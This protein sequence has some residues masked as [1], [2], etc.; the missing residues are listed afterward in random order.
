MLIS[1]TGF[2][3]DSLPKLGIIPKILLIML[4]GMPMV[5]FFSFLYYLMGGATMAKSLEKFYVLIFRL[6]GMRLVT[7]VYWVSL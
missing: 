6:P 5:F 3:L 4:S 1:H 7:L 2:V